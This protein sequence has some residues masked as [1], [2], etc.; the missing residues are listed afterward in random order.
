MPHACVRSLQSCPTLCDPVDCSPAGSSVQGILQ[1]RVLE[2]VAVPS[3]R[4]SSSPRDRTCISCIVDGFFSTEPQ[5]KP[6][7]DP[8]E[9]SSVTFDISWEPQM[10]RSRG[11]FLDSLLPTASSVLHTCWG[12]CGSSDGNKWPMDWGKRPWAAGTVSEARGLSEEI[13]SVLKAAGFVFTE[14]HLQ[15]LLPRTLG[16]TH[17]WDVRVAPGGCTVQGQWARGAGSMLSP[18]EIPGGLLWFDA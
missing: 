5:G 15:A 6:W 17:L 9:K 4:G 8:K 18:F 7:H 13:L 16:T 11:C 2:W 14:N 12:R 10:T 3:S 1:A